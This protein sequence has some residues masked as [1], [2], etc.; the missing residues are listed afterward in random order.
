MTPHIEPW[1]QLMPHIDDV[2]AWARTPFRLPNAALEGNN[3]LVRG[4]S[5]RVQGC[6]NTDQLM[7]MLYH[8]S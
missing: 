2:C 3:A 5:Q 7:L 6:R 8:A 4:V 1:E